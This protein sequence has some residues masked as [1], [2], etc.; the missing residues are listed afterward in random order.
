MSSGCNSELWL[1]FWLQALFDLEATNAELKGDLR[2]LWIAGAQEIDISASRKAI[3]I[4]A[5]GGEGGWGWG[6]GGGSAPRCGCGTPRLLQLPQVPGQRPV[7]VGESQAWFAGALTHALATEPG[8]SRRRRSGWHDA[9]CC[10]QPARWAFNPKLASQV[11]YRLLKAYHK[12]QQRLVRELEKKFSGESEACVLW[13]SARR[14]PLTSASTARPCPGC[15]QRRWVLR[16]PSAHGVAW[17]GRAAVQRT[18]ERRAPQHDSWKAQGLP[19][20]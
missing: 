16:S 19:R 14:A 6:G 12:I 1:Q 10:S 4:K 17:A 5:R 7:R 8:S 15:R 20:L 11:P 3:L 2:D 13:R 18:G 9:A